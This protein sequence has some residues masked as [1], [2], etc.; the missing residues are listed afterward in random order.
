MSATSPLKAST[1]KAKT[2][3]ARFIEEATVKMLAHIN[4]RLFCHS[5]FRDFIEPDYAAFLEYFPHPVC[6]GLNDYLDM[7]SAY[8]EATPDYHI[9]PIS[10]SADVNEKNGT[11]IVWLLLS[12]KGHP[13]N[14]ERESVTT[15]HWRRRAG[16][17]KGYKQTGIR[18]VNWF[19]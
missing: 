10:I 19:I 2:A 16:K 1:S 12:V 14:V 15:V 4:N 7:Y 13:K 8:A 6:K 11:A 3:T 9:H 17:W 18:G 5:D